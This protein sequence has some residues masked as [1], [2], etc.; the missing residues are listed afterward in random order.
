VS[1]IRSVRVLARAPLLVLA[2]LALPLTLSAQDVPST[3]S[4]GDA[5]R[6]ARQNAPDYLSTAARSAT[7]D[8]AVREAYGA[9]LPG[10]NVNTSFSWQGAGT[11]RFGIFSASDFGL[12]TSTSYYSSNYS[13]GLSYRLSGST[14]LAP[15]REKASRRAT[16]AQI[17]ASGHS[18]DANVSLAYIA[19]R[20]AMDGVELARQ[21]LERADENL[22]LAQARVTVGAAIP[23]DAKQAEVDRGR[24]QVTLLQAENLVLTQRLRLGETIGL[25]LDPAVELTTTFD[26]F[27][28]RWD[29]NTLLDMATEANPDIRAARASESASRVSVRMAKTAYLPSLSLQA[30]FS[31]FTRQ[32][33]NEGYLIQQAQ[34]QLASQQSSCELFNS[35]SA[36][37]SQPIPGRPADC[38]AYVLTPDQEAQILQ[39]NNVFPF[40]FSREPLS[41]S[42]T[43]SLPVFQGF[44]RE[45]QIEEAKVQQKTASYQL[46]ARELNTRTLVE[47]NYLNVA[48]ARQTIDLEARNRDLADEQLRLAR[49]R[50]RVGSGTFL[51]LQDAATVKARADQAYL[52]AVYTFFDN[53]T[54]LEAAVGQTLR[55]TE[56]R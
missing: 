56:S 51:E 40:D 32:A 22:K 44:S 9:L 6:L 21:E 14:L 13:V 46:R 19:V 11:Q 18:L 5:I 38:S 20:R 49:E 48:T 27:D 53:F 1:S 42:L 39:S 33:G 43:L 4:L 24:A 8:W 50:Y 45:R 28:V 31:G 29:L 16:E 34:S 54:S 35:I 30:G 26:V 7:A 23:L 3:L 25:R 15:G 47:T 37:L 52:Y 36:G 2:C 12:A 17:V 41:V 10:A 55:N